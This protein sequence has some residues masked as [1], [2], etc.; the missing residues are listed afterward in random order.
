MNPRLR[1]ADPQRDA[2]ALRAL[3]LDYLTWGGEQLQADGVPDRGDVQAMVAA[4]IA[5]LDVYAPPQGALLVLDD[6][7]GLAA[8]IALRRSNPGVGEVKRLYVHPRARGQGLGRLLVEALL[9]TARQA[10]YT[11]LRLDSARFMR[12]AQAL[13]RAHGFE[14][15]DPYPGTDV[16]PELWPYWVFMQRR[17]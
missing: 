11:E 4:D 13:Y 3:W 9:Q 10:G 16:P 1:Q 2:E 15:T 12:E 5:H 14:P 6:A 17:L 7:E 8:T